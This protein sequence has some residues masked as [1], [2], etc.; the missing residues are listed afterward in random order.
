MTEYLVESRRLGWGGGFGG[1]NAIARELNE[2]AA[3][4]WTIARTEA[5]YQRWM[6]WFPRVKMLIIWERPKAAEPAP[7]GQ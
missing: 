7:S 3:E 2:R 5:S 1:E 6:W 4:G